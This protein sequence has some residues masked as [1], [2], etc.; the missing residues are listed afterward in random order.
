M[1]LPS[2][3]ELRA[4]GRDIAP[5]TPSSGRDPRET[6]GDRL[7]RRLVVT[8]G[9][10]PTECVTGYLHTLCAANG[11][12]RPSFL[13]VGLLE[14]S[15]KNG[16]RQVT[17]DLLQSITG[18]SKTAASRVCLTPSK[19]GSRSTVQLLGQMVH[20]SE[21]RMD[22]FRICPLCVAERGRHEA[23]WHLKMVN[24]CAKHRIRLLESCSCCGQ[25]LE[26]NRPRLGECLCGAD[27]TAQRVDAPECSDA[28][29]RLT[30]VLGAAL[31]DQPTVCPV[32]ARMSH[33]GHLTIYGLSRLIFVLVEQL[34]TTGV[35]LVQGRLR[36]SI[37]TVDQLE[38][39]ARIL[40]DWPHAFQRHLDERY[41]AVVQ[42]DRFGEA[43][44]K[45]FYW[46]LQTLDNAGKTTATSE[47][48]FLREQVYRFG[49]KYLPRERLVRGRR[50]ESPIAFSWATIL[51]AA[52]E[53]GMDPRTLAKR[54]K[55]GEMPAIEADHRRRNR[56]LLVDMEWLRRWKVSQ[57]AP[58]YVRD[59][60]E[61]LGISVALLRAARKAGVYESQ[62][63]ART[64][65]SFSEEDVSRFSVVLMR[66]AERYSV[67]GTPGGITEGDVN[68]RATKSIERRVDLL[69]ELRGR[70]PEIWGSGE[71]PPTCGDSP[72]EVKVYGH[73]PVVVGLGER[74]DGAAKGREFTVLS[75]WPSALRADGIGEMIG[76]L[77]AHG[78]REK[79]VL[80]AAKGEG[81][82]SDEV[83]RE[84]LL[85]WKSEWLRLDQVE[86]E[87]LELI[88]EWVLDRNMGK[89][90]RSFQEQ[91]ARKLEQAGELLGVW[92]P[93]A[94]VR[95][96]PAFQFDGRLVKSG[97][98]ELLDQL[99]KDAHGWTQVRWLATPHPD[100][101]NRRP[102][103]VAPGDF[104]AIVQAGRYSCNCFVHPDCQSPP[105]GWGHRQSVIC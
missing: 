44:R 56:N 80:L 32:P 25:V 7:E 20:T 59:A 35:P 14:R 75:R 105:T 39:V 84:L 33:L 86:C 87:M 58:V 15:A 67:D 64:T 6:E 77:I 52:A 46:A 99:P 89:Y 71:D 55:S 96:Y 93:R 66:L 9:P 69:R 92:L 57:Y 13:L 1:K 41:A 104:D 72:V 5:L 91:D 68:L 4:V 48:A 40:D 90:L 50:A 97:V 24:W 10:L 102:I 54:V 63:H 78:V 82:I 28:L 88:P 8:P 30:E 2:A 79:D 95:V 100:L 17:P 11:Y 103:D 49:A 42:A 36:D 45:A 81:S 62:Y 43:F 60:A 98:R 53:I 37:V 94:G 73:R 29:A 65:A 18:I 51:E 85:L 34:P 76:L 101:A 23:A 3:R 31:Y 70:H 21:L 22:A 38:T 26:W 74:V 16:Y 47:F 83:R 61:T 27:L 12:P 19:R